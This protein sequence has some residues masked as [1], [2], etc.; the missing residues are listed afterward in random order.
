MKRIMRAVF[1]SLACTAAAGCYESQTQLLDI[2]AARQP[3]AANDGLDTRQ[4][5]T[6]HEKLIALADGQYDFEQATRDDNSGRDGAWTRHTVLVNEL[7]TV[8]GH[9]LFVYGTWDA[10]ENAFVY[11]ILVPQSDNSWKAVAPDCARNAL[12]DFVAREY[13]V[14]MRRGAKI[15]DRSNGVCEFASRD[16]L[17]A[18]LRD[19]ANTD[20]FW[21]RANGPE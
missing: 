19:F 17:M 12:G 20:E 15:I 3:A 16:L 13:V 6:Y 4:S 9:N 8:R 18:A 10:G 21:M 5:I 11:G 7:G 14:A 1:V 2:K